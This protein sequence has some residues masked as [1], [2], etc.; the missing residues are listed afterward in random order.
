MQLRDPRTRLSYR[1]L[2]Q[3]DDVE[4]GVRTDLALEAHQQVTGLA[5]REIPG[6]RIDKL[7][8]EFGSLTRMVIETEEGA[9]AMGKAVGRYSTFQS[10]QLQSRNRE[11]QFQVSQ[12]LADEIE[13]YFSELGIPEEAP[14]LV[15]GL[16]NWNATPDNIGPLTTSKLLVTRHLHEYKALD[17]E[18]LG[19]MRPVAALSPGV[20]GLTGIETAEIVHAVVQRIQPAAVICVDALASMSV[21]R[22]GTTVQLAD[23]G[24]NPGSGVGNRRAG[25]TRQTLGVPVLALGAPT[26]IYATTIVSE[27]VDRILAMDG[28]GGPGGNGGE[29]FQAPPQSGM[30]SGSSSSGSHGMLDPSLID[31]SSGASGG[32][33]GPSGI[34]AANVGTNAFDNGPGSAPARSWEAGMARLDSAS[35]NELI[36]EIL[37]ESMGSLVVTPKEVDVLVETLS[38]VLAD[39]LNEALHPGVSAEE[40]ALLR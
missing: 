1:P 31:L 25:L 11:V 23:V 4:G 2:P 8:R 34:L 30:Q 37:G 7:E 12:A 24:I 21:E 17:E 26:V 28:P 9:L 5:A 36:K 27:A 6:V 29:P 20:L 35:R 18:F 33:H 16:G 14:I 10:S 15:V 32:A 3:P 38:D 19:R 40:A 39:G 22:V 13:D